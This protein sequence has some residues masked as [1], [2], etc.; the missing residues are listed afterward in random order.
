[1][2][3]E[4]ALALRDKTALL[5]ELKTFLAKNS[6]AGN[7]QSDEWNDGFDTL[8]LL[9]EN[10]IV[11]KFVELGDDVKRRSTVKESYRT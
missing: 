3:L 9:V 8:F 10:W 6:L 11:D 5:K 1:M 4:E 7:D 2:S